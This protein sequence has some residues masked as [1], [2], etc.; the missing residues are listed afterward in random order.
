[1]S[2]PLGVTSI[3]VA[4]GIAAAITVALVLSGSPFQPISLMGP[5]ALLIVG[6]IA[7]SF[8]AGDAETVI[9]RAWSLS[10][11]W[12]LPTLLTVAPAR[13][14]AVL[15]GAVVAVLAALACVQGLSGP[16]TALFDHHL[17]Y[18]YATV[19]PML[20]LSG[21]EDR[22]RWLAVPMGLAI[23]ATRSEGAIAA[24]LGGFVVLHATRHWGRTA[25]AG[26]AVGSMGGVLL[27]LNAVPTSA[28]YERAV[29][30]TAGARV[31]LRGGTPLGSWRSIIDHEH[32]L[33]DAS[34]HFPHHAHDT[35]LQ[36]LADAGPGAWFALAWLCLIAWRARSA[37]LLGIGTALAIGGLTQD[38][39]GDL[40]V[41]R[42]SVV[43]ATLA[44][45]HSRPTER[46]A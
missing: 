26:V 17:T 10:T 11:V 28:L 36:A 31:G 9:R 29:L 19:P 21:R 38:V 5:A 7:T 42:A 6:W 22:W 40:E 13:P 37:S 16:A 15:G 3:E 41:L 8:G 18:A 24:A 39:L 1:M 30:W 27:A 2:L 46:D 23:L 32:W 14:W 44:L 45:I 43:W 35:A 33:L 25:G 20:V 34:F 4:N 12:L